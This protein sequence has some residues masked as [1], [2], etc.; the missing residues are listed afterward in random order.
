MIER[1]DIYDRIAKLSEA[2]AVNA[3]RERQ[4]EVQ[5]RELEAEMAS[6][7]DVVAKG[8]GVAIFLV[9]LGSLLGVIIALWDKIGKIIGH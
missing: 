2:A 8:R 3:E 9:S 4:L 5:V 6:I 1:G 7:R